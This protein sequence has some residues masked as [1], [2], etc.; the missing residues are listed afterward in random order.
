MK[1]FFIILLSLVLCPLS[2]VGCGNQDDDKIK[3]G[4]IKYLNVTEEAFDKFYPDSDSK[5]IFYNDLNNMTM[6]LQSGQIDEMSVYESVAKYFVDHNPKFEVI[7]PAEEMTDLFCCSMRDKDVELKNEFDAAISQMTNDGTLSRLVKRYIAEVNFNETPPVIRMPEFY[8]DSMVKIGVTGDLPMLDYIRP[9]GLPAGFNTAV[10][11]EI[12]QRIEKNFVL[13]QVESGER[14]IALNSG[15]VDVIFWA[16]VPDKRSL[17]P[18][19]FDHP[20]G[21]TFTRPY[22]SDTIVHVK[23]KNEVT[24]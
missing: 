9:D 13:V 6:A 10:L 14:A 22:F 21:M 3:V 15:E 5:H 16:V 19:D 18:E 11:A 12:S 7:E 1:K 4:T 24:R 23:L 8:N 20:E 17:I 2:L